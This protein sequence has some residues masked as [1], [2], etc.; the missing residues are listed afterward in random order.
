MY[1]SIKSYHIHIHVHLCL[2]LSSM[3]LF[4]CHLFLRYLPVKVLS[5]K[6]LCRSTSLLSICLLFYNLTFHFFSQ[7]VADNFGL[8]Y[9]FCG[10]SLSL[11]LYLQK[12][13]IPLFHIIMAVC[14][15]RLILV[16]PRA[17]VTMTGQIKK[18]KGQR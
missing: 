17:P 5:V 10:V 15:I 16:R 12:I 6:V 2:L 7:T 8:G 9:Q 3:A 4:V 13:C 14:H 1:I 18:G 11:C